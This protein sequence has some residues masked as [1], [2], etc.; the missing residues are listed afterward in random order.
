MPVILKTYYLVPELKWPHKQF[1]TENGEE[2]EDA[3]Q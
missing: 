1:I 3:V 2:R